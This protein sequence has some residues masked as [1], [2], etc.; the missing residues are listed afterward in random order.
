MIDLG[1][2]FQCE[3]MEGDECLALIHEGCVHGGYGHAIPLKPGLGNH[4]SWQL[5]SKEP[6]HLEP[7]IF[8][9]HGCNFHG[10]I[11]DGKWVPA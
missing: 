6:L 2:G 10:F 4:A 7:S 8:C 5:V 11:R 9:S 3:L 1:M